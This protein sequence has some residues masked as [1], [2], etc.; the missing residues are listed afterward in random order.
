V[1]RNSALRII[2]VN[3]NRVKEGL[4]VCEDI[5]RFQYDDNIL[6]HAF[7]RLRHDCSQ[8]LLE[9]PVSYRRL[10]EARNS[11]DDVGKKSVILEKKKPK[12]RDLLISN[13]KRSEEALRVLEEASKIISP[14]SSRQ[15]QKLRFK[16]YE[17]EQKTLKRI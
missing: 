7:K 16:L 17:L 14:A 3:F 8:V 13:M 9:F 6:T 4:R 2:D 1:A 5:L 12:W 10:I 11:A 15:F